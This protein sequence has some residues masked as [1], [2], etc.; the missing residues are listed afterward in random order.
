MGGNTRQAAQSPRSRTSRWED[1]SGAL[2][3]RNPLP[4]R[5][6]GHVTPGQGQPARG[7]SLLEGLPIQVP[8]AQPS[9]EGDHR[10]PVCASWASPTEGET[11]DCLLGCVR[12]RAA[13]VPEG[14]RSRKGTSPTGRAGRTARAVAPAGHV[15]YTPPSVVVWDPSQSSQD[16][17]GFGMVG[18]TGCRGSAQGRPSAEPRP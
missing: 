14:P 11:Q 4:L 8:N 12:G 7:W 10:Q 5:T 18:G 16:D 17:L 9:T 6:Q 2:K 1:V 13:K 15:A 3:S